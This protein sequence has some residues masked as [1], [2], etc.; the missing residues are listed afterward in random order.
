MAPIMH[1]QSD[2]LEAERGLHAGLPY[3]QLASG[4]CARYALVVHSTLSYR[5]EHLLITESCALL[6]SSRL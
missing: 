6:P 1:E 5:R 2:A 4:W 3:V